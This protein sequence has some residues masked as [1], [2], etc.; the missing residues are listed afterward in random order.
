V[1]LL[2]LNE[3]RQF[4]ISPSYCKPSITTRRRKQGLTPENHVE[5]LP[6]V[7]GKIGAPGELAS[8]ENTVVDQAS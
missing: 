2:Y 6:V 5:G 3:F 4:G 1:S 8:L 7:V